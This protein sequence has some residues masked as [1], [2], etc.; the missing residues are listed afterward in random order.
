MSRDVCGADLRVCMWQGGTPQQKICDRSS[1]RMHG[2]LDLGPVTYNQS[3]LPHHDRHH[4]FKR[5]CSALDRRQTVHVRDRARAASTEHCRAVGARTSKEQL[6]PSVYA[7]A[8]LV[9]LRR[10][11][12]CVCS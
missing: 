8:V 1:G 3:C 10:S 6:L 2:Y 7:R 12:S 4:A 9:P 5:M 11:P